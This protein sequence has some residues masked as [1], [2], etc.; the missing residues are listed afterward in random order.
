MQLSTKGSSSV[1]PPPAC[2]PPPIVRSTS[3]RPSKRSLKTGNLARTSLT[4]SNR[5]PGAAA[6]P[7]RYF[8]CRS[9][10]WT[11]NCSKV[12]RTSRSE[13][14]SATPCSVEPK[15][16][17]RTSGVQSNGATL[18]SWT[19]SA[20]EQ[21]SFSATMHSSQVAKK[22]ASAACSSCTVRSSALIARL[23]EGSHQS[24][25]PAAPG[26]HWEQHACLPGLGPEP[27][28]E[29]ARA[30]PGPPRCR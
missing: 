6:T 5:S 9:C 28:A 13:E 17:S 15:R 11:Q 26:T 1:F 25:M 29:R 20:A 21:T 22:S 2:T 27:I 10:P 3:R 30:A 23:S 7:L 19:P 4:T 16:S 12:I 24:G 18:N 8:I 14:F